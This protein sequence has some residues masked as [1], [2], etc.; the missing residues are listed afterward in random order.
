MHH[1]GMGSPRTVFDLEDSSRTKNP[2]LGL[3]FKRFGL[4]LE[5]HLMSLGT[6]EVSDS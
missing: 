1:P 4:G 5:D 6:K 3:E 2:G